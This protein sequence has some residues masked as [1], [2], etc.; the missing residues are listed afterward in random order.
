MAVCWWRCFR[1]PLLTSTIPRLIRICLANLQSWLIIESWLHGTRVTNGCFDEIMFY[2]HWESNIH[3]SSVKRICSERATAA[4][5]PMQRKMQKEVKMSKPERARRSIH[6]ESVWKAA[7]SLE[8]R[9]TFRNFQSTVDI[10]D[11]GWMHVVDLG[12]MQLHW[13]NSAEYGQ[14]SAHTCVGIYACRAFTECTLSEW[15]S[16]VTEGGTPWLDRS[17]RGGTS[18]VTRLE[19][20]F[21]QIWNCDCQYRNYETL[22]DL[23]VVG[24]IKIWFTL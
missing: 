9:G 10:R 16:P 1:C 13:L 19:H 15:T 8:A 3:E 20:V 14:L 4:N 7:E 18:S 6:S 24:T 21:C 5:G 17:L 2:V 23:I 11:V 22:Q 12:W